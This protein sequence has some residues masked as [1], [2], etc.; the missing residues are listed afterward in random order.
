MN[1]KKNDLTDLVYYLVREAVDEKHR[2]KFKF[3]FYCAIFKAITTNFPI[4]I[5]EFCNN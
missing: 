5:V 4:K 3:Y 1:L 2:T